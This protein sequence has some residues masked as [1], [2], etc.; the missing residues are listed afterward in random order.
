MVAWDCAL[1]G[2]YIR[3]IDSSRR[4]SVRIGDWI[5]RQVMAYTGVAGVA[6]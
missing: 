5:W 4:D 6:G 1:A 3:A 2:R